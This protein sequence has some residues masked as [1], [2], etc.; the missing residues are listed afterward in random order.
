MRT[1]CSSRPQDSASPHDLGGLIQASRQSKQKALGFS[2]K[3]GRARRWVAR[4]AKEKSVLNWEEMFGSD[5]AFSTLPS[6]LKISKI[7]ELKILATNRSK[8]SSREKWKNSNN[9]ALCGWLAIII[10]KTVINLKRT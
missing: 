9:L 2:K 6:R 8:C 5:G 10:A 4:A 3:Q 1:A 7:F